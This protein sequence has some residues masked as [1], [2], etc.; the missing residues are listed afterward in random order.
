MSD[1]FQG[2]PI[3]TMH[4]LNLKS[5]DELER[6]LANFG[7]R[8]PIGLVLPSL[9]SELEGEALAKIISEL[10]K[11]P[12]LSRI[13]IGLDKA[14]K[15]DFEFAKKYFSNLPQKHAILW[16]DGPRLKELAQILDDSGLAPPEPGKGLSLIHI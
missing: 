2:G 3:A 8:R 4:N 6:E 15:A 11:V 10:K 7:Q 9:F 14:D 12:Y 5:T 13:V 1:F 16:H